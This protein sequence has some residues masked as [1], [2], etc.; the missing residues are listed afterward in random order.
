MNATEEAVGH[1][2]V[3]AR[4]AVY[5][6]LTAALDKPTAEQH[7]WFSN[8]SF[9]ASMEQVCAS[10][11]VPVPEGELAAADPADHEARYIAC[12]EVGLPTPPV[13]LLASHYNRR[14]PVTAVIHEHIL[15][16]HRFGATLSASNREPADHLL[17]ELAFLLHLD[18]LFLKGMPADSLLLARRDFLHRHASRWPAKA[19]ADAEEKC[20]PTVYRTLL[21]I[22]AVAVAE[23]LRLTEATLAQWRKVMP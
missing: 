13:V 23:D 16:Y 20:L 4:L 8:R 17:S 6:F 12:F 10:F 3:E 15:F 9:L 14:E 21:A 5:R 18:R 11:G 7:E 2:V 22:L 19:A 1:N